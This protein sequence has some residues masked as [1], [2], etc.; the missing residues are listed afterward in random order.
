MEQV[1]TCCVI[2]LLLKDSAA[3]FFVSGFFLQ[4]LSLLPVDTPVKNLKFVEFHDVF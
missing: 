2:S 3:R 1:L 4:Q